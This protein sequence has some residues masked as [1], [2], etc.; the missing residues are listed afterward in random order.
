MALLC[1]V[2]P[3]HWDNNNKVTLWRL[4][5]LDSRCTPACPAQVLS[6]A[7]AV[8]WSPPAAVQYTMSTTSEPGSQPWL[9]TLHHTRSS[10]RVLGPLMEAGQVAAAAHSAAPLPPALQLAPHP[11]LLFA[12][13]APL[14]PL[15][16]LAGP[17]RRPAARRRQRPPA[18]GA[19]GCPRRRRG[20]RAGRG[21]SPGWRPR[22]HAAAAPRRGPAAPAGCRP[23]TAC[24]CGTVGYGGVGHGWGRGLGAKQ[25]VDL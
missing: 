25:A 1:R 3:V 23:L 24:S 2:W 19:A 9:P 21:G 18:P 17:A 16:D 20:P 8:R 7:A 11:L 14:Q 13:P 10:D 5:R 22:Q 12:P 6:P 15:P 4:M